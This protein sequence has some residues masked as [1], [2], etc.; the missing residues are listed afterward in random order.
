[1]NN[2]LNLNLR[3]FWQ[4]VK[5][6]LHILKPRLKGKMVDGATVVASQV[7]LFGH[8]MPIIGM[9]KELIAPIFIGTIIQLCL[10]IGHGLSMRLMF[11][12]ENNRFID[13]QV[14]LP[15]SKHWLF[16]TYVINFMIELSLITLPLFSLGIIALGESFVMVEPHPILFSIIFLLSLALLGS[17][18]LSFSFIYPFRWFFDNLWPRRLSPLFLL[19]SVFFPWKL[20]WNLS[21][22]LGAL[23]LCNPFTYIAEGLRATLIGGPNFLPAFVCIPALIFFVIICCLIFNR[24]VTRRLDPV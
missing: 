2:Q 7:L 6:D 11:D 15:I 4:L 24:G 12:L 5:R 8:L 21:P 13:Y 18:Q 14:I 23:F 3:I 9:P 16:A 17:L 19:A 20:I 22:L 1:M 10:S